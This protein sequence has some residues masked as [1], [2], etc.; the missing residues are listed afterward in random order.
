MCIQ[1]RG[2]GSHQH[3][4][5]QVRY[6]SCPHHLRAHQCCAPPRYPGRQRP[7]RQAVRERADGVTVALGAGGTLAVTYAA[8]TMAATTQVIFDVTGYFTPDTSG[9][10]YHALTPTRIL[11]S[12]DGTGGLSGAFSSYVAL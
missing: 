7:V 6:G 10:T 9:A 8:P 2:R 5:C 11:D 12:R 4:G 3:H 1:Q